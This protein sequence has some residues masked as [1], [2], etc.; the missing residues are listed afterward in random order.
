LKARKVTVSIILV[1]LPPPDEI[2]SQTQQSAAVKN[3]LS[4]LTGN[5]ATN[6]NAPSLEEE[7]TAV[8]TPKML[9]RQHLM[10]NDCGNEV[11]KF[12]DKTVGFYSSFSTYVRNK[13]KANNCS[14]L[15][16]LLDKLERGVITQQQFEE[17]KASCL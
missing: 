2:V 14:F 9:K 1:P 17:M 6:N 7:M 11:N 5:V 3:P 12:V 8:V 4:M 16:Q 15:L 10:S 13:A